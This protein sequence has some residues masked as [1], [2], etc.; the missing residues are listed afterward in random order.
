MRYPGLRGE[1]GEGVPGLLPTS[2]QRAKQQGGALRC[3]MP[4]RLTKAALEAG[5]GAAVWDPGAAVTGVG[6]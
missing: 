2:P 1:V 6:G 3:R 4:N 5:G